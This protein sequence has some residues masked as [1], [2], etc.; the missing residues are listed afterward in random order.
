MPVHLGGNQDGQLKPL[1]RPIA[2][3]REAAR[4][5]ASFAREVSLNPAP[6]LT[7]QIS[8]ELSAAH[9]EVAAATRTAEAE[10]AKAGVVRLELRRAEVAE[11]AEA[12]AAEER[13]LADATSCENH[14]FALERNLEMKSALVDEA[15]R[16]H[17]HL[18]ACLDVLSDGLCLKDAQI[19]RHAC[20]SEK[21][22]RDSGLAQAR[23]ERLEDENMELRAAML[24]SASDVDLVAEWQDRAA[25]LEKEHKVLRAALL[26][27]SGENDRLRQM[28]RGQ[29][30]E[31]GPAHAE[32]EGFEKC[33]AVLRR[34]RHAVPPGTEGRRRPL[35][36]YI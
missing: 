36:P 10:E 1:N 7:A 28:L 4:A 16:R 21:A 15:L 3:V 22:R 27:R 14:A 6:Y 31:P 24:E 12:G 35:D 25:V 23:L 2:G 20:T 17:K 9:A 32:V 29:V 19:R 33:A 13:L 8:D 5:R 34:F 30:S 11:A 26:E 18:Q